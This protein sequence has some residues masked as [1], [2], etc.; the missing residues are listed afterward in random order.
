MLLKWIRCTVPSRSRTE[1]SKAQEHWSALSDVAG[2]LGQVG[3]WSVARSPV[4]C[5]LGLWRDREAYKSFMRDVHDAICDRSGQTQTYE[6]IRVVLAQ[7]TINMP[8]ST[9]RLDKAVAAAGFLRVTDCL[10]RPGRS[11][12]FVESQRSVWVPGMKAAGGMLAGSFGAV[13]ASDRG[14]LVASLWE[15]EASHARYVQHDLAGLRA[16]AG[17]DADAKEVVGT[18][19]RLEPGWRV[20][21]GR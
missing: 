8:G 13:D 7:E 2:F 6:S 18:L 17:V 9:T 12:S 21:A 20:V 3:G 1:F 5:V 4:A 10:V 19:V 14:Y 15:D 16:R 11:T